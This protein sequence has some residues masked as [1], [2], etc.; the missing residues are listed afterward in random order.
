MPYVGDFDPMDDDENEFFSFDFTNSIGQAGDSIQSCTWTVKQ[1]PDGIDVTST[2]TVGTP[3]ISGMI[4][5]QRISGLTAGVKYVMIAKV[6]T[7]FGD[8]LSLWG[9]VDCSEPA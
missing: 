7:H 3:I 2:T 6:V 1:Q 5:Y 9:H 4:I 8:S